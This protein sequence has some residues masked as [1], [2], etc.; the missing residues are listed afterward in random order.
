MDS[1]TFCNHMKMRS[2]LLPTLVHDQG[3]VP[4]HIQGRGL[5]HQ[6][7]LQQGLG[8]GLQQVGCSQQGEDPPQ[9]KGRQRGLVQ[10]KEIRLHTMNMVARTRYAFCCVVCCCSVCQ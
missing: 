6:Q 8:G 3:L 4:D 1:C 7:R 2:S 9:G 5:G 10:G